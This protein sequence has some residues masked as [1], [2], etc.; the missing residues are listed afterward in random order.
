VDLYVVGANEDPDV[1]PNICPCASNSDPS[2]YPGP[3]VGNHYYCELGN[4]RGIPFDKYYTDDPLWDGE[5]CVNLNNCCTT[6]GMPWFIREFPISQTSNIE[7]RICTEE[8]Y[9]NEGILIEKLQF[10][11]L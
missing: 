6:P 2:A 4:I 3:F 9:A 8:G 11:V 10:Y 5:G 1:S 7:A